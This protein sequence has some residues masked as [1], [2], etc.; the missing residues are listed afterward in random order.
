MRACH[1]V[2]GPSTLHMLTGENHLQRDRQP[3][4]TGV[5]GPNRPISQIVYASL[6]HAVQ[7]AWNQTF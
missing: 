3:L 7:P 5:D 1:Q 4:P 2:L 6:P